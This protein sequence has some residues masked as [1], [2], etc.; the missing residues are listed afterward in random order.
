VSWS[1]TFFPPRELPLTHE[2]LSE[3]TVGA[4]VD[5]DAVRDVIDAAIP[6]VEWTPG[7]GEVRI[8]GRAFDGDE[9]YELT[10]MN[11]AEAKKPTLIVSMRC[12]GRI[13]SAPFAQRLCDATGWIAFD[14]RVYL[15]Q[16]LRP[17]LAGGGQG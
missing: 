4:F 2:K 16:P 8:R 6:N 11:H 9:L 15:F 3:E 5:A 13:D 7:E 14:D 12:S 10:I 1:Y 17:P